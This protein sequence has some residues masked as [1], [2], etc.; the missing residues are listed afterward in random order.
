MLQTIL[1]PMACDQPVFPLQAVR[2]AALFDRAAGPPLHDMH[3]Y[4]CFVLTISTLASIIAAV[5]LGLGLDVAMSVAVA[6]P[7]EPSLQSGS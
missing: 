5:T 1:L 4:S 2:C 7:P 3:T 6:I